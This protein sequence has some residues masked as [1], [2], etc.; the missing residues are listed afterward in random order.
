VTTAEILV[1]WSAPTDDVTPS[2]AI[3]VL[4]HVG[5]DVVSMPVEPTAVAPPGATTRRIFALVPGPQRVVVRARD[6]AGNLSAESAAVLVDTRTAP[7]PS[8]YG[9]GGNFEGQVTGASSTDLATPVELFVGHPALD[10]HIVD[11]AAGLKLSVACTDSGEVWRWGRGE[12]PTKVLGPDNATPLQGIVRVAGSGA[13]MLALDEDGGIWELRGNATAVDSIATPGEVFLDIAASETAAYALRGDGTVIAWGGNTVG[14]LGNNGEDPLTPVVV[15]RGVNN[16]GV[17]Q[18]VVDIEVSGHNPIALLADGRV[19]TWG[20]N[21]SG[22]LGIGVDPDSNVIDTMQ[23]TTPVFVVGLSG[24]G[25]LQDVVAIDG[26][27]F[28][29]AVLLGD[30]RVVSWGANAGG[31]L[32]GAVTFS[33]TPVALPNIDDALAIGVGEDGVFFVRGDGTLWTAAGAS[34]DPEPVP[35]VDH[36]AQ[37]VGGISPMHVLVRGGVGDVPDLVPPR[38]DGA[39]E[40]QAESNTQAVV[41]WA[42][43]DD[44]VTP[45][46]ALVYD[47]YVANQTNVSFAQPRLS[48]PPGATMATLTGLPAGSTVFVAVRARDAAGNR[49][50][51]RAV[52]STALRATPDAAPPTFAGVETVTPLSTRRIRVSWVPA[53]DAVSAPDRID[54]L[55]FV[56]PGPRPLAFGVPT[57]VVPGGASQAV[58]DLPMGG[59][60]RVAVRARDAVGNVDNNPTVVAADTTHAAAPAVFAFGRNIDGEADGTPSLDPVPVGVLAGLGGPIVDVAAGMRFSLAVLGDGSVWSWGRNTRGELGTGS[61]APRPGLARVKAVTGSGDLDDVVRVAAQGQFAV[62]L[63]RDGRVV[64]WGGVSSGSG[65]ATRPLEIPGAPTDVVAVA[66]GQ[67]HTLALRADGTVTAWGDDFRGQLGDGPAFVGL[68]AV[69]L[70]PSGPGPLQGVVDVECGNHVSY[71]LLGDGRLVS[72]GASDAGLLG[73]GDAVFD[74]RNRPGFVTRMRVGSGE[75]ALAPVFAVSAG[76]SHTLAVLADGRVVAW[77]RSFGGRLGF[78]SSDAVVATPTVVP[79]LVDVHAVA[80]G[81]TFSF[82]LRG[83]GSVVRWGGGSAEPEELP[84]LRGVVQIEASS[85][86]AAD[87]A[88]L[89]R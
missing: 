59:Q 63:L 28:H 73:G 11:V 44:D 49:D 34:G 48:T 21:A 68:G 17:L 77:G 79:G 80:A 81:G 85:D 5:R 25:Q 69:V 26:G 65:N 36:V 29:L 15:V 50:A 7:S 72:W 41:R 51:N 4:I 23:R 53:V 8:F 60:V 78:D 75:E 13:L 83:D 64:T 35:G 42:P 20:A 37:V 88:V 33:S 27:H 6:G 67:L 30:G 12:G 86:D 2:A 87:H 24:T 57:L 61:L 19:V 89:A 14:E 38:F 22:A 52:V 76:A 70:T 40:V 74:D 66:A 18:N 56:A 1:T 71:A 55:V 46:H 47:V 58:L 39:L 32:P 62:A 43:A 82:A 84:A 45:P 16:V 54:H 31:F 3:E 10:G 9:F